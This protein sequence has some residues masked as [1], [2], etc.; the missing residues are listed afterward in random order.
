MTLLNFLTFRNVLQVRDPPPMIKPEKYQTLGAIPLEIVEIIYQFLSSLDR[1]CLALSC[2]SLYEHYVSYT[3]NRGIFMLS[4]LSRTNLLRHLK[5]ERWV[6]CNQCDNLHRHTKWGWLHITR[7]CNPKP[8]R[9]KFQPFCYAQPVGEVD[10]CPCW[11]ITLHDKRHPVENFLSQRGSF[12]CPASST[13]P[14]PRFLHSCEFSHPLAAV[15]IKS[16]AWVNMFTDTFQVENE[17]VFQIAKENSSLELFKK[18]SLR[19]SRYETES[20][21]KDF[22]GEA[23]SEFFIGNESSNWYQCHGWDHTG[24]RPY[25]FMI[26][27]HRNLGGGRGPCKGWEL[28]CHD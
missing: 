3:K 1:A 18:I 5:N 26:L 2:K 11:T 15:Y 9:F 22:F 23:G 28:N 13:S 19:L 8:L 17:F 7:M 24:T 14:P 20:W 16:K 6:Y 25:S 27:L 4:S 21:L 10:L 12:G